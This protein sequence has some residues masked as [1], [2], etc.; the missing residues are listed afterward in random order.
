MQIKHRHHI[1]PIRLG[2][3][4]DEENLTPPISFQLHAAFHKD[5]YDH[6][7]MQ[8]DYIAWKAL[9]G[10]ITSEEARLLA[11]KAGQEKSEKYKNSRTS[12]HLEAHRSKE[13]CSKGGKMASKNLI[14]WQKN[15]SESFKNQCKKNAKVASEKNKIPHEYKGIIYESI[16]ALKLAHKMC[17]NAFYKKLKNKQITRLNK[18]TNLRQAQIDVE[19]GYEQEERLERMQRG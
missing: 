4:N 12:K 6:Y 9:S 18:M 19:D 2:G 10:R 17:N 8:E 16:Q 5:L 11:A 15:N 13:N 7:G 1:L 14:E 3:T